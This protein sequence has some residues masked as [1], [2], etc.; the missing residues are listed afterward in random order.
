MDP[1]H[2]KKLADLVHLNQGD[3]QVHPPPSKTE[4][5][6]QAVPRAKSLVL[7]GPRPTFIIKM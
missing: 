5:D 6:P 2:Q 3:Q 7:W 1:V 4:S